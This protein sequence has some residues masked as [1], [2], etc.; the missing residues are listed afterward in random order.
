MFVSKTRR[1]YIKRIPQTGTLLAYTYRVIGVRD[2]Q[3]VVVPTGTSGHC[4]QTLV[5]P[6]GFEK[7]HVGSTRR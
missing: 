7:L 5:T 6:N 3:L 2:N 1:R 4:Y